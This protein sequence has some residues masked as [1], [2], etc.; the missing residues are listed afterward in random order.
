MIRVQNPLHL[1]LTVLPKLQG[2]LCRWKNPSGRLR[3]CQ[4]FQSGNPGPLLVEFVTAVLLVFPELPSRETEALLQK[5]WCQSRADCRERM[6]QRSRLVR[7][8]RQEVRLRQ[9]L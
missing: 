8:V 7:F 2:S 1:H 6:C 3:R 9:V 4:K 5:V